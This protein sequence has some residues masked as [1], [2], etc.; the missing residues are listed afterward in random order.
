M[1]VWSF[2]NQAS[3]PTYDQDDVTGEAAA[4][5]PVGLLLALTFPLQTVLIPWDND[6]QAAAPAYTPE[7]QN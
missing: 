7:T 5:Q 1:P 6:D 4:G 2:D 3:A